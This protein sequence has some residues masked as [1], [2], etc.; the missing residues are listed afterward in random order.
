MKV[1][2]YGQHFGVERDNG[3][4]FVQR[5]R[6]SSG[7]ESPLSAYEEI[8]VAFCEASTQPEARLITYEMLQARNNDLLDALRWIK[9][10]STML[11]GA[12]AAAEAVLDGE[13]LPQR[14]ER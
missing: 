12:K 3:T 9:D 13:E 8:I 10:R 6:T 4:V 14:D 7:S 1:H 2:D 5:K 11:E